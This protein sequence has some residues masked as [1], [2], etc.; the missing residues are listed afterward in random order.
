MAG[1]GSGPWEDLSR[2]FERIEREIER[3]SARVAAVE[4][5]GSVRFFRV[6]TSS[7]HAV[8]CSVA[9]PSC[10]ATPAGMCVRR[11]G[12]RADFVHAERVRL[13][14]GLLPGG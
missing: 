2:Y 11:S 9:C 7:P 1:K 5:A 3:L 14:R 8:A 6:S 10:G 13:S 12:A 4:R